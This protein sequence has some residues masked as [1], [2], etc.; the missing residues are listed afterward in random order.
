MNTVELPGLQPDNL[1]AFLAALGLLRALRESRASWN[2][3]I[4]WDGPPWIALLHTQPPLERSDM[5]EATLDGLRGLATAYDFGGRADVNWS[6][7]EF[8]AFAGE[9]LDAGSREAI[10]ILGALASDGSI[11]RGA[12]GKDNAVSATTLCAMSGQGHQ[13]FLKELAHLQRCAEAPTAGP[14][15]HRALFEAWRYTQRQ[16]ALKFRWDPAENRRYAYRYGNPGQER[17]A[18]VP[19]ANLLAALGFPLILVAPRTRILATLAF[20]SQDGEQFVTW[21]IWNVPLSLASVRSLLAHP[22][23][24]DPSPD[25][26]DLHPYGVVELMRAKRIQLDRYL[27]FSRAVALWGAD[28]RHAAVP[29][30]NADGR[31][32]IG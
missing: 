6:A 28:S 14:D 16:D 10:S 2:P 13:H 30:S 19:G 27:N 8:R 9:L 4:S 7:Q 24:V 12:A 25:R 11:K 17:A 18:S 15:I 5:V 26:R 29:I 22:K 31:A 23:L 1:L 3:R 21:P 20:G 32:L